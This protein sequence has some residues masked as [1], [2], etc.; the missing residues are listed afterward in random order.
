MERNRKPRGRDMRW[1][2][3]CCSSNV[4]DR[5]RMPARRAGAR[6]AERTEP[7]VPRPHVEPYVEVDQPC[8]SFRLR[9][10][11]RGACYKVLSVEPDTSAC[12][13]KMRF[14][15]GYRRPPGYTWPDLEIFILRGCVRIGGEAMG[16]GAYLFVPAGYALGALS[17]PGGF[18]ALMLYN[19][20]EPTF[21]E[22][23]DRPLRTLL[24][25]FVSMN[26]YE[27]GPWIMQDRYQPGVATG[28]CVKPLRV[29]LLTGA[30]TFLY[31]MAPRYA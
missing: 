22:S 5:R 29:D 31:T 13:L 11:T 4:E 12:S 28:C 7:P 26:G 18:A 16:E 15:A 24:P 8:R 1:E 3:G 6:Y 2:R 27:R 19:D 25:A 30:T 17:S 14:D 23:A 21:A 10:F 9:S 20:G